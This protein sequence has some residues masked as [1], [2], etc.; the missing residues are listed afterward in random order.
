[1]SKK[2]NSELDFSKIFRNLIF[3]TAICAV[4]Y[5]ILIYKVSPTGNKNPI[6]ERFSLQRTYD[7][8]FSEIDSISS[9]FKVDPNYL[10]SL[11]MLECSGRKEFEPRF[12]KHIFDRLKKARDTKGSF[13]SINYKTISDAND[14]ALKNL[15]TSWGPFQLMGYQCIE[16][17]VNVADIRG[18]HAVYWG[19]YW[20]YKRYGKLLDKGDYK[21][22][23]HIHNTGRPVPLSGEHSTHDPNYVARGL[24]YM[25]FFND[26]TQNQHVELK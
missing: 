2:K 1:M 10:L 6:K 19:I 25:T 9:S 26:K 14:E 13:G 23:F 8:Y 15:A 22:A 5:L 21:N 7:N 11:T 24:S 3:F 16:L 4:S 12:E 17:G 18:K 20:I